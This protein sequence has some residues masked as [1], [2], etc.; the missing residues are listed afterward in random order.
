MGNRTAHVIIYPADG[1]PPIEGVIVR[2]VTEPRPSYTVVQITAFIDNPE[3]EGRLADE[4][5]SYFSTALLAVEPMGGRGEEQGGRQSW[6]W[7]LFGAVVS[8]VLAVWLLKL[9]IG[10]W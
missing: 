9:L 5:G 10:G 7:R 2:L 6:Q 3:S 4:S 1:R 8:A